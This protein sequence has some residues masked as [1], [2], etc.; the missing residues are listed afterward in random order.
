MHFSNY[1]LEKDPSRVELNEFVTTLTQLA[2]KKPSDSALLSQQAT[3]ASWD[4]KLFRG[5]L[6]SAASRKSPTSTAA[7]TPTNFLQGNL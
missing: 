7:K 1:E 4:P 6:A 2:C 5:P 3:Q